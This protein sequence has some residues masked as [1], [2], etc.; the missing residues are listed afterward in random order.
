MAPVKKQS[1]AKPRPRKMAPSSCPTIARLRPVAACPGSQAPA[2]APDAA[3]E[4]MPHTQKM[5]EELH[6]ETKK[7]SRPLLIVAVLQTLF[8][9]FILYQSREL[10]EYIGSEATSAYARCAPTGGRRALLP[11]LRR[12][13]AARLD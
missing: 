12:P 6:E 11:A 5:L 9:A 1:H 3:S 4:D 2:L 8:G 13:V 7:A 10:L